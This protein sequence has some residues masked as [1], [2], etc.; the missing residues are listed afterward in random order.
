MNLIDAD[1]FTEGIYHPT[2]LIRRATEDQTSHP[3]EWDYWLLCICLSGL[4]CIGLVNCV[5]SNRKG[6]QKGEAPL[7]AARTQ[8]PPNTFELRPI[9]HSGGRTTGPSRG[10]TA[11]SPALAAARSAAGPVIATSSRVPEQNGAP[12]AYEL[13]T[14]QPAVIKSKRTDVGDMV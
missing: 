7:L 10:A 12:P 13:T 2:M 1:A 9:S 8:L 11:G 3:W 4:I 5:T 6:T 14:V